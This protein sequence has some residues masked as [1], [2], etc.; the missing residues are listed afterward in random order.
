MNKRN[1][2]T[3]PA[4]RRST[5]TRHLVH[6]S[7]LSDFQLEDRTVP[8][9]FTNSTPI[10]IPGTGTTG[11]ATPYPSLISVTGLT[12]HQITKLQVLLNGVGHTSPDNIDALLVAPD[13]TNIYLM[14]DVGGD[15]SQPVSGAILTIADSGNAFT[16]GQIATGTFRPTNLDQGD[17]DTIS[18]APAKSPV[19]TMAAFNGLNPNGTWEL[20]VVDDGALDTG[21]VTGG[22][23]LR[24][25]SRTN[26]APV[27]KDDSYAINEDITLTTTTGSAPFGV[28]QNDTDGDGDTLTAALVSSPANGKL[29]FNTNGTFT[30]VPK[31]NFNGTDSFT[32]KASDGIAESTVAKVTITIAAVND[33]PVAN[34]DTLTVQNNGPQTIHRAVIVG[35]DIDPDL[36]YR[37]TIFSNNFEGLATQP[38]STGVTGGDGTDWGD[39][40]AGWSLDN[41]TTP[42]GGPVE[43]TGWHVMDIDSWIGQQGGQQRDQFVRGG[44]TKHGTVV[45]ADGDALD[46]FVD[47]DSNKYTTLLTTPPISL[48]GINTNSLRLEFDSSYRP[49]DP[50][51]SFGRVYVSFDGGAFTQLSEFSTANTPGGVGS[52]SRVNDH[53]VYNLDNATTQKS[54]QFRWGYEEAGNDWWWAIDNISVTGDKTD[55]AQETIQIQSQPS[56][57]TV[58]VDANGAVIYTPPTP[59]FT[60]TTSFTY[61]LFD[62]TATSNTATVNLTVNNNTV[63][64][65][66]KDD[67]FSTIQGV[68]VSTQYD[69]SVLINDT[70][71]NLGSGIVGLKAVL[72]AGP[73][74]AQGTLSFRPDGT[75]LFTPNAAFFGNASFT[76]KVNDGAA[77]SNTATVTIAVVQN[78]FGTPVA[79]N[80]A[81][82]VNNNATLTVAAPGVLANDTDSD[83]NPLTAAASKGPNNLIIGP[84]HGTLTF[85][86]DGSFTYVPIPFFNGTDKFTYTAFDGAFTSAPAT[87]T[88]TVTAVNVAPRATADNYFA[89]GSVG[90][91]GV[92]ANDRDDG[93]NV[94]LFL[95]TFDGLTLQAWNSGTTATGDGTD[96]TDALPTGWVR[97]NTTTPAPASGSDKGAEFFGWHA[98]DVDSWVAQQ[99]NQARSDFTRSGAGFHGTVLVGDGDAYDDFIDIDTNRMNTLLTTPSVP[100]GSILPNSLQLEFDS[101]FRPEAAPPGNQHGRIEVSYDNGANWIQL[102]DL[103]TANSGGSGSRSR[104]NE[105]VTLDANN[106]AGATTAKFRFGYLEAQNDWWWAIDNVRVVGSNANAG[107]TL[108]AEL[109]TAPPASEGTL[110]LNPNGSFTF[111]PAGTFTGATSFTYQANDGVNKSTPATVQIVTA[112]P[113]VSD[114][115]INNG[116][117]QRSRVQTL[118]VTFNS[119]VTILPGAF[120][121][122]RTSLPGG[123]SDSTVITSAA[124]GQISVSTT[125]VNA[126]SVATLTFTGTGGVDATSLADGVWQLKVDKASVT[127]AGGGPAMAADFLT[128]TATGNLT[129]RIYRLFGDFNRDGSVDGLD[130]VVF[131]ATLNLGLGDTG[132]VAAADKNNDNSIDGLDKPAFDFNLNKTIDP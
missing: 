6:L 71:T 43:F 88:I 125:V 113:A 102:L 49:E 78:N 61:R 77:D 51:T 119:I 37:A 74:A 22:W 18:G 48:D 30:Y 132:Y 92:L 5:P 122:T 44:P 47:I 105:H 89:T 107:A 58:S 62:G 118:T 21:V 108:T 50:G 80:D 63:A 103:N 4:S 24:I 123:T 81:Y 111:T 87:V 46:D 54:V 93:P 126:K 28:L 1:K 27:A 117:A 26:A 73:T 15:A 39:T 31:A 68:A 35:N 129:T 13:G 32:Y 56:Q 120:T 79:N 91:P 106:P 109:V 72:V 94:Q 14:S 67:A 16:T 69:R 83:G 115:Q 121:L 96:W 127:V 110:V 64:A 97:D 3:K 41:K 75:F 55:P 130:K 19:T 90:A 11:P 114:V 36:T 29:T 9:D 99:G 42:S 100:L 112:A 20:R 86:S 76:Y 104:T 2:G 60:G 8:T 84:D 33:I 131:D 59:T 12:G 17:P 128:P 40:P 98:M 116:A 66:A 34:D 52:L 57:G 82:S 25:D 65:V 101:S 70:D 53:L 95:E 85:N 10:T 45:V 124:G 38:F 23:T 7:G